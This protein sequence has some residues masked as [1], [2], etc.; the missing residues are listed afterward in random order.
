M[1]IANP[2][3]DSVFKWLLENPRTARYF[4]ETILDET[5]TEV[6]LKPKELTYEKKEEL[7]IFAGAFATVR[8]DFVAT[9][10]TGSGTY[11][12]VL[13]EIQNARNAADIMLFR[14]YLAQ[15][16]S[17]KDDII[18]DG[19]KKSV[20]LPIVTIYFFGFKLLGINTA[21]TKIGRKYI[22]L[23][24]KEALNS[25]NEFIEQLTHDSYVLLMMPTCIKNTL[26]QLMMRPHN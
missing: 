15:H 3:L 9:I 6:E 14:N 25:I 4:I 5:V 18:A 11:K 8:L 16:Y 26:T 12:K 22:D 19:V 10:K 23:Q 20:A 13:V 17:R 2:I 7:S 24:K 21:I 1:L